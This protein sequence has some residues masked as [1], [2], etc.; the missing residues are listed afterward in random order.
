MTQRTEPQSFGS[1]IK[2]FREAQHLSKRAL[3]RMAGTTAVSIWQWETG[4]RIPHEAS[5]E[6]IA[7]ALEVSVRFLRADEPLSR[8]PKCG[9]I[10]NSDNPSR[11]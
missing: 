9:G 11:S 4:R 7:R 2:H 1:K 8:C 6:R 10:L 5:L 3:A